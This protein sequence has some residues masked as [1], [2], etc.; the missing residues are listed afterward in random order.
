[1]FPLGGSWGANHKANFI[2]SILMC[3][4]LFYS[5]NQF[6]F[7]CFKDYFQPINQGFWP[8]FFPFSGVDAWVKL[9]TQMLATLPCFARTPLL[10]S[11]SSMQFTSNTKITKL[12]MRFQIMI[13]MNVLFMMHWIVGGTEVEMW[14]SMW[15]FLQMKL[16]KLM[17]LWAVQ[18]F[19]HI[20]T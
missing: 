20:L 17:K 2:S 7:I 4:H 6:W 19:K 11:G 3:L 8:Q 9:H 15:V 18:N 13:I 14:W 1:M 12:Q 10:A 16:M 5:C